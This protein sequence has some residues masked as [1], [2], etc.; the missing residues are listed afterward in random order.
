M[1]NRWRKKKNTI[2]KIIDS[3]SPISFHVWIRHKH[4]RTFIL[5]FQL[6]IHAFYF[7]QSYHKISDHKMLRTFLLKTFITKRDHVYKSKMFSR[8]RSTRVRVY[9]ISSRTSAP[10]NK[11][12]TGEGCAFFLHHGWSGQ[13]DE[14]EIGSGMHL[15]WEI[16]RYAHTWISD[17]FLR[18]MTWPRNSAHS[19]G[20]VVPRSDLGSDAGLMI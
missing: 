4:T 2:T 20:D 17:S 11:S 10:I 13:T 5:D 6:I 19:R 14:Q 18:V 16:L 15:G 1:I 9:I 3:S 7:V 12:R 8:F